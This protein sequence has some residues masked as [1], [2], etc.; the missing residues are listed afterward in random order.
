ML[1]GSHVALERLEGQ[2]HAEGLFLASHI[3]NQARVV[4]NYLPFGLFR[5]VAEFRASI[6]GYACQS[7]R[8]FYAIRNRVTDELCAT[9]S[10]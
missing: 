8:V 10:V 6:A 3:E 5:T 4:R 2:R 1:T 7:R 9:L